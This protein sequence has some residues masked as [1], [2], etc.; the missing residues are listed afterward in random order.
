MTN[1]SSPGERS[2]WSCVTEEVSSKALTLTLI[3]Y[4]SS[5]AVIV[6]ETV[7]TDV[8]IARRIVLN[9]YLH[10]EIEKALHVRIVSRTV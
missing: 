6:M 2:G 8:T 5:Q 10:A 7:V 4:S 1:H 3:R 9:V